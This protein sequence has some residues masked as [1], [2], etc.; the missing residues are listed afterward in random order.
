MTDYEKHLSEQW[1]SAKA[2]AEHHETCLA[3]LLTIESS[4]APMMIEYHRGWARQKRAEM[5]RILDR[6]P[7]REDM[8]KEAV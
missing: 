7:T 2:C 1:S 4:L 5:Q 3:E 6:L 8:L